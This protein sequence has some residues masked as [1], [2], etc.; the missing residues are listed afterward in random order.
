MRPLYRR[1]WAAFRL[2]VNLGYRGL[3]SRLRGNDGRLGSRSARGGKIIFRSIPAI[4]GNGVF[5]R[6]AQPFDKLRRATGDRLSPST[7]SG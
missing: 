2:V 4:S 1:A 5:L 6:Q 7:G 3:D